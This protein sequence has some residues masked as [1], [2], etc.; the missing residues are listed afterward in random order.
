MPSRQIHFYD[1][2]E[3]RNV[4]SGVYAAVYVNGL[5]VWP[6][7][8]VARMGKIIRISVLPEAH[9]AQAARALDVETGAA[10]IG[11]IVPFI[12]ERRRCGYDD[13]TIYTDRSNLPAAKAAVAAAGL[14]CRFW[15]ATLDGTQDIDEWAVQYQGGDNAPYDLSVLRGI[16]DF[17]HPAGG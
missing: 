15:V 6:T 14:T 12:T 16:D 10:G 8:E 13:A 3:P 5:Y 1:A 11:N 7:V 4:P 17:H 9:W 2:A